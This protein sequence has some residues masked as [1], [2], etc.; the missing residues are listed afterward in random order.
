MNDTNE[1]YIR[2]KIVCYS[3]HNIALRVIYST[4]F[5]TDTPVFTYNCLTK[6]YYRIIM[7]ESIVTIAEMAMMTAF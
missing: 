6:T 2:N 1:K 4:S 5:K 7:I 3:S